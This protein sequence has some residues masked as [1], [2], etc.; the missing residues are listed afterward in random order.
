META[1]YRFDP[2]TG[3]VYEYNETEKAYFFVGSLNGRTE[4]D[5]IRDFEKRELL[6]EDDG[7][8]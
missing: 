5:F 8:E 1:T 6:D 4:A 7:E 2:Q 3:S